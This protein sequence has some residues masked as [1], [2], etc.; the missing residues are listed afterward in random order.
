MNQ[1]IN[2][3]LFQ[4]APQNLPE[5]VSLDLCG[6]D[7][8]ESSVEVLA[9]K[10]GGIGLSYLCLTG[11][12]LVCPINLQKMASNYLFSKL[13]ADDSFLGYQPLPSETELRN[14]ARISHQQLLASIYIQR[15]I[16]GMLVRM[17]IYREKREKC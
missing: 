6:C 3:P 14:D 12:D 13:V 7:V 10:E 15:M 2:G 1:S 9:P 4:R 17:G 8:S 5:L 16:R 11:C